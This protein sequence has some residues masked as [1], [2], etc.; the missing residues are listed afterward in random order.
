MALLRH[1]TSA[2]FALTSVSCGGVERK[3]WL[4]SMGFSIDSIQASC[5][6]LIC[7]VSLGPTTLNCISQFEVFM[8]AS[9]VMTNRLPSGLTVILGDVSYGGSSTPSM[10]T[11]GQ[12]QFECH[13]F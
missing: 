4:L 3:T 1:R 12:Y 5:L 11:A 13:T 9:D 6:A 10:V 8:Y 2:G 7:N